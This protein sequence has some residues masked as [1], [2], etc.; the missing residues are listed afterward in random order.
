MR[1]NVMIEIEGR[2]V[3]AGVIEGESL[4]DSCF[5]YLDEYMDDPDAAPISV[6]LPFQDEPF[7]AAQTAIFFDGLLPEGFTRK[8][9]AKRLRADDKDYIA[10]LRDLG[11][12]CLGAIQVLEDREMRQAQ[13][14]QPGAE[15]YDPLQ[16]ETPSYERMS[17]Q[18]IKALAQ[19]GAV[20][21]TEILAK[22]HLSLTG[23]SGKVGLYYD[24]YGRAWYL[25]RGSAP[26]NFIVKQSHVRLMGIVENEQLCLMTA[27]N[28]GLDVPESFII[29]TALDTE[30]EIADS[31]VLFATRRFDRAFPGKAEQTRRLDGLPVPQRLHQE[32]F[33]QALGIPS[34]QKYEVEKS[35]YLQKMF[36]LIRLHSK[37]P[38][39]DRT[40]L[41]DA[42]IVNFLLGN[43]DCHLK[44]FSFL[45]DS[46]L[47]TMQLA[48]LY[49]V[50]STA[51]YDSNTR[52]NAFYIGD[53]LSLDDITRASFQ[54]AAR[55]CGIGAKA[56]MREFDRLADGF[57]NALEAAQR[58]MSA[59]GYTQA[60]VLRER[61]LECGG[62]RNIC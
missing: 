28:L 36:R 29:N 14:R 37:E 51:V 35:G 12:E 61:I 26:S 13:A 4:E 15:S 31:D 43:A 10:I 40:R 62:Y 3:R 56:A 25:P 45:Y 41:W 7:T 49:D 9:V 19:E 59:E 1:L 30:E 50:V 58:R 6:S 32:D 38:V 23:A 20:K 17:L 27:G 39:R 47:H 42:V 18:Q 52:D 21:S 34:F 53:D 2:S 48:P 11:R 16:F 46:S 33:A 55:E 60:G 44:N 8:T 57:E 22:T 24:E 54:K 5:R